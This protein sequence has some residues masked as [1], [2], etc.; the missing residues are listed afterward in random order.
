MNEPNPL[1]GNSDQLAV[2]FVPSLLRRQYAVDPARKLGTPLTEDH[3]TLLWIDIVNFSTLCNR[4]MTDAVDGVEK[5]TGILQDHYDFVLNTIARFGGQ[6]LFFAGDGLMSAWAGDKT[7][8]EKSVVLAAACAHE[9]L[10]KRKTTDDQNEPISIH[11][12]LSIGPLH[13]SENEG[14]KGKALCSFSGEVFTQLS[15][16]S[17]NRA[18]NN[19]LISNAALAFLPGNVKSIPVE[20]NTSIL[21]EAPRQ[22]SMPD[23][24]AIP[25]MPGAMEILKS[26]VPGTLTFPLNRE[27]LKWI[28]EIRP[29]T[30]V[31]VRI[32]NSSE[33]SVSKTTRFKE[34][35]AITVPLVDKY[36]GL[37]NQVW[38]DEKESNMLICFGPP[39]SAHVD[40]PER[41][42]LL[43]FEIHQALN[44]SNFENSIGVSTGMAYC[45]ILGNDIL[46]Q[47]TVIGD[48]VNLSARLAGIQKKNIFCDKPTYISSNKSIHYSGHQM[49]TVKGKADP[50]PVYT[51]LGIIGDEIK[52]SVTQV[53]VGRN[54]ELALLL[55]GLKRAVLGESVTI[56]IEGDSGMG[57][58]KLLADFVAQA[59]GGSAR[60]ITGTADF[61]SR[62]TPY[63][64]LRY[65]I[66][67]LLGIDQ[68]ES[69]KIQMSVYD[70]LVARFGSRA[71]L[72]N[73]VL[74]L[75]IPDS[76]EIRNMTGTQ[77]VQ[78]THDFLMDILSEETNKQPLV[79]IIDDAQWKDESTW[80]LVESIR[81]K[82]THC[83]VVLSFQKVEGIPQIQRFQELGVG[84]I[85]MEELTDED[86]EA[87]I[88]A[89]LGVGNISRDVSDLIRRVSKGNPFF[90][91]EL[92]GSLMDQELLMFENNSCSFVKGAGIE[93]LALP[94][95]V[96][97]AIRSRIDRLGQG[98]QLS[99]RV[100]SVV[101]NRFA[102]K[103]IS[104]IYPI[105][106][107]R[108]S[109]SSY[110]HEVEQYGFL[111]ETIVDNLNGYLFN[112]AMIVE[113]A[114]EMTLSEQR[115]QLHRESAEWYEKNFSE[116]LM[117]F[118]MRLANHWSEANEK[119]KAAV[120]YE[121]EAM[122]LFR[123]GY[124]KE[125][126]D[127]GM[128]GVEMLGLRVPRDLP[129]I[130][131]QIGENFGAIAGLMEGKTIPGLADHKKLQDPKKEKLIKLLMTLS[132]I[133][134][135]CQQ[136]ELFALMSII[137][138]RLTL[139]HG[140][141]EAAA[142]VY[143]M[144]A[145]IYKALTGDSETAFAWSQLA[146]EVDKVNGHTLQSRVIFIHC[147]F[148][149][150]WKLPLSELIPVSYT[151][152][153]AGFRSGDILYACFNLS[154]TVVLKSVSGRH[155]NEVRQT[156]TDHF[157]RNNQMVMNA[158]FHLMHEEQVAKAFQGLT[159]GNT[160]LTDA[161]YDETKDIAKICETDL[162]N[163]IAYYLVSKMKLN[164]HFGHWEEAIGWGEKSLP[165][166]P[167]FA[168]QPGHI[169]L[170]Q[171]FTLAA[172]YRAAETTGEESGKFSAIAQSGIEK[173]NA[174]ATL[175]PANFL[176]KAHLLEAI[177]D[178]FSGDAA[179]A[180]LK[181]LQSAS[182]AAAAGYIQDRGLAFEH[183]A[184]MKKRAGALYEEDL[185]AAIEAYRQWGADAKINYLRGQFM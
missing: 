9:I 147:W 115:R 5:L 67:N 89:K 3:A 166:L 159:D 14:I 134:H 72:L 97:G 156:A 16:A 52:K 102:E 174:W 168:N 108:K 151:G 20:F 157:V 127:V 167:A 22:F 88:C 86:L 15:L 105:I 179:G 90:C 103:I 153:D 111:N 171:F 138:E 8:A 118:Y 164:V 137:C 26:Y 129:T 10:E 142:E 1:A 43:A 123:L 139:E 182:E 96:K 25:L 150:L 31:F 185:Q 163:Q 143:A 63:A 126:L 69:E 152:A 70:S 27:K 131:A 170:E 160:S 128:Q 28:A 162:F 80:K 54:K 141:G 33:G 175:C 177:R 149:A 57:K 24:D 36:D 47:Y 92:T 7:A 45:G 53:S 78:A 19:V 42:A 64:A 178:G 23:T 107:E 51:P 155:L 154:L 65:I 101:G 83:M 117:P 176:H 4:L 82:L 95:T 135:Q 56:I 181:F 116:N 66:S 32:P 145:I 148:I 29:V 165:L 87:L 79:I 121:M 91:I 113:V 76:D 50:L 12:I 73:V 38:L 124:A 119:E 68:L 13:L 144:F 35:V 17:K 110:L 130:G 30:I 122:R 46:R 77:R 184:R 172:L 125:A 2:S 21:V 40:N 99:L 39:P 106:N 11:A 146:I 59:P 84:T 62:N 136:G 61:V 60:I 6:P 37:I 140:N 44:K 104:S 109:V 55:D 120:Y 100:G 48:V 183:L 41:G 132:P 158:A 173:M 133:A 58:T 49:V 85:A 74:N 161:K 112:N 180:E 75:S 71:S 94:E 93:A 81:E 169:E 114:Y 98:S 34:S 18:V